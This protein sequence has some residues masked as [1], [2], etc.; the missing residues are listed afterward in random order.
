MSL[1]AAQAFSNSVTVPA[2]VAAGQLGDLSNIAPAATALS[3]ANW[4]NVRAGY[5]D[6]LNGLV[7]AIW[8]YT[9]RTL[10]AFG[11]SV[12]VGTNNDKT[13]YSGTATNLPSDYQQR[14]VAVTLPTLPAVTLAANQQVDLISAPNAAAITA[15]QSGLS[16]PGTAQ[17]ITLPAT[18]ATL[19]NQTMILTTLGSAGAGLTSIPYTGP[20]AGTIQ[21]GLATLAALGSP[22]QAGALVKL[23]PADTTAQHVAGIFNGTTKIAAT[24][25][26][27]TDVSGEFPEAVLANAPTGSG[28]GAYP[29]TIT[30]TDGTNPIQG[31]T[32]RLT[33]G[34]N[35]YSNTSAADGTAGFSLNAGTYTVTAT[36]GGYSYPPSNLAVG[37]ATTQTVAM[38]AISITFEPAAGHITGTLTTSTPGAV[39]TFQQRRTRAGCPARR[40]ALPRRRTAATTW[41]CRWCRACG[42][43]TT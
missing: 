9:T 40:R 23:D 36:A 12:T 7:A 3:T 4:T 43:S 39:V 13:G 22:M 10:S 1:A 15:I 11:F 41:R 2:S 18:M 14:G 28:T 37:G 32:V 17:T 34:V 19:A 35:T 25:N 16:K 21:S 5:I 8:G 31:A 29:V 6:T 42:T 26:A 24:F 27:G 38:A 20:S 33:S 30:V